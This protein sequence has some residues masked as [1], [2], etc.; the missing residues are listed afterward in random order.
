MC[1]VLCRSIFSVALIIFFNC[2]YPNG[3]EGF[4]VAMSE[5]GF[6]NF[7]EVE[8]AASYPENQLSSGTLHISLFFTTSPP[9]TVDKLIK[10]TL[11]KSVG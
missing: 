4:K 10:R 11:P 7:F 2:A 3:F 9:V 8:A 6:R 1:K 5:Y